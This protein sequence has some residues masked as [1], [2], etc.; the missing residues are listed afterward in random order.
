MAAK[1]RAWNAE[2]ALDTPERIALYL[3][4]VFEDGDPHLISA[5]I[6]DAAKAYGM[7]RLAKETGLSRESLYR[8][9]SDEGNPELSTLLKVLTVLGVKLTPTVTDAA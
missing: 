1:T 2:T 6:G 4:A 9:L 3:E 7:S 5:A 8:S